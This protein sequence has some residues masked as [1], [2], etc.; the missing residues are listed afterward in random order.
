MA[1]LFS[2][3]S[4]AKGSGGWF[5]VANWPG[6]D[7]APASSTVNPNNSTSLPR[8]SS[9]RSSDTGVALPEENPAF[10][11][12]DD[13]KRLANRLKKKGFSATIEGTD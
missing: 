1:E 9:A 2:S 12:T 8:M 11:A 13:E 3:A 10:H 4:A 5:P 7:T 6:T